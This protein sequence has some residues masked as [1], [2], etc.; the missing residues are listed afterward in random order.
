VGAV[1]ALRVMLFFWGDVMTQEYFGQGLT[2]G[3]CSTL[4][5]DQIDF[6][7]WL[8]VSGWEQ[9]ISYSRDGTT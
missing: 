1:R 6:F 8:D 9:S 5:V 7:A 4:N 2:Y 3:D